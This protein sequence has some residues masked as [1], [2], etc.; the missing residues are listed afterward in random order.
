MSN[1]RLVECDLLYL[2][3]E[4]VCNAFGGIMK[5]LIMRYLISVVLPLFDN[6]VYICVYYNLGRNTWPS[7]KVF[8]MFVTKLVRMVQV[9]SLYEQFGSPLS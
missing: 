7:T 1:N 6:Y 5:F 4:K 2:G 8:Y 3:F 9:C